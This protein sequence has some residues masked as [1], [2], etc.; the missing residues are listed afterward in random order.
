MNFE[1][2]SIPFS[3][4][5]QL[6]KTDKNYVTA[7]DDL[8]EFYKYP[9]HINSFKQVI[10]DKQRQGV[11]RELLYRVFHSQYALLE[12]AAYINSQINALKNEN[13]FTVTTAHQ[14][15][16]FTGPLYFIYKIVSTINLAEVLKK[17]YPGYHFVPVFV[18]GGEDH[19]FEEINHA[20]L[21]NKTLTWDNG[22]QF[23]AVGEMKTSTLAKVLSELKEIVGTSDHATT[24]YEL[25]EKSYTG[26]ATFGMAT[27]A[28]LN[29]LFAERGLLI[30][31]MNDRDL[32]RRFIP[33][34]QDELTNEHAHKFVGETQAA[35]ANA[36]YHPQAFSRN[37]NLFYLK[38]QLRERIIREENGDFKVNNTDL[39]F[40]QSAM[41]QQVND[42]PEYFSPNVILRPLYQETILPN[43]A[44]IGG[45][46]EI[47]YWLERKSLFEFY[48]INFPMLIRRNSLLWLDK[49][50]MNKM[51]K[52]GLSVQDLFEKPLDLAQAILLRQAKVAFNLEPEIEKLGQIFKDIAHKAFQVDPTLEKYAMAECTKLLKGI[53][54]V[55]DRL[56]KTEKQKHET[57]LN[58][59]ANIQQKLFPNDGLQERTDNFIPFYIKYGPAW[60]DALIENLHPL[61]AGFDIIMEK[62]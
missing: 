62:E 20:H 1:H 49:Q 34:M 26:A 29:A 37:I 11:D 47:A 12:P 15:C 42:H 45:G 6:S 58:Q 24:I 52:S 36:G 8:R 7:S 4:I 56:R 35:L 48:Q 23:G 61:G 60:M 43:L 50:T 41:L 44:Y 32:K 14:P 40:S 10:E 2:F 9:V 16:L 46:G 31:N 57:L 25:I 17:H 13:T 59:V 5:R 51:Q 3:Q 18:I 55:E 53:E 39:V 28:L 38:D 30:L 22:G 21:Y 19:D 54:S 27:Q 33:V